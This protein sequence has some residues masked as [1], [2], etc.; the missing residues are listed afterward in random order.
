MWDLH[1]GLISDEWFDVRIV[2]S[3]NVFACFEQLI[4]FFMI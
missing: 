2:R 3:E 4:L 1:L